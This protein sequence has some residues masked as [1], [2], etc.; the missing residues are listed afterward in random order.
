MLSITHTAFSA[1]MT[2]T[3]MRDGSLPRGDEPDEGCERQQDDARFADQ[4]DR[5][6]QQ[7]REQLGERDHRDAHRAAAH[8]IDDQHAAQ[9]RRS[10]DRSHGVILVTCGVAGPMMVA[11]AACSRLPGR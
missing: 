5:Q 3:A 4:V 8:G 1:M 10:S 9:E 6:L 2:H 7:V 11:A